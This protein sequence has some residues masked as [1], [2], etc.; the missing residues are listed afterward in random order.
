MRA[1]FWLLLILLGALTL[2]M[3]LSDNEGYVLLVQ[4]PYRIELSLNLFVVL[5][6]LGFVL[7]H[8]AL[9]LLQHILRLPH[10][11]RRYRQE[12]RHVRARAA[13]LESLHS[14]AE[15]R[16]DRAEKAA[17]SALQ[18]GE[19]SGLGALVAARAAHKLGKTDQRDHYLA[20]AER[21]APQASLARLLMQAELQV[22]DRDYL[23]ALHTLQQLEKLEPQHL[24]A[25]RLEL[26]VR[27][28]LGHWDQ[29]LQ[30]A[31]VLEKRLA[32][33]GETLRQVRINAHRQQLLQRAGK[34]RELLACWNRISESDQLQTRLALTAARLLNDAGE[35]A[36]AARIVEMSLTRQW[37]SELAALYGDCR[38]PEPLRQL[39]QAEAWLQRHPGD[40]GLLLALGS[41]CMRQELWGKAQNY[42][43]ASVSIRPSAAG[44]LA[45]A[46]LLERNDRREEAQRHYLYSL[47]YALAAQESAQ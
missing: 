3:V 29:V 37:D 34:P 1:L 7:L 43:E 21:L 20:E 27:Q 44:H 46:R 24:P 13:L 15:G 30:L 17:A 42:L 28:K 8:A 22:D 2:S 10:D 35:G 41:L 40:A 12:Q 32:L 4:H 14:L 47:E 26:K 45:L 25:L 11:V 36:A 18:G 38:E 6:L 31:A 16:Y 9:R 23:Q 33:G 19:D 39:Q 5:L